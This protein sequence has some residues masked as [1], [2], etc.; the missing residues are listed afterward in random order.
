MNSRSLT[1]LLKLKKLFS[2][3]LSILVFKVWAQSDLQCVPRAWCY[4]EDLELVT[5]LQFSENGQPYFLVEI[6]Q[7]ELSGLGVSESRLIEYHPSIELISLMSS[8]ELGNVPNDGRIYVYGSL[9]YVPELEWFGASLSVV[10]VMGYSGALPVS[11]GGYSF[12]YFQGA[13]KVFDD[14]DLLSVLF[15]FGSRAGQAGSPICG[16]SSLMWGRLYPDVTS[17]GVVDDADLIYVLNNF[18]RR[19]CEGVPCAP[20]NSIRIWIWNPPN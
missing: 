5:R 8:N 16:S 4:F 1:I 12:C 15:N 17:D 19:V 9:S 2:F 11:N 6:P 10:E 20:N 18:G 14:S 13:W 3:A 7:E